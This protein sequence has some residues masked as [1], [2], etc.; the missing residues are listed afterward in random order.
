MSR[1]DDDPYPQSAAGQGDG[2]PSPWARPPA[3]GEPPTA[4][5]PGWAGPPAGPDDSPTMPIS[6]AEPPTAPMPGPYPPSGP[7]PP[8]AAQSPAGPYP[9]GGPTAAYPPGPYQPEGPTAAY[10]PAPYQP[11]EPTAAYP[12]GEPTAAYPPVP[13]PA[14]PYPPGGAVGGGQWAAPP[15]YPAPP[16]R[17]SGRKIALIVGAVLVALLCP[18]LV[19]AGWLIL[20]SG[21]DDRSSSAPSTAVPADPT[22][23]PAEEPT[24]EPTE[25][26]SAPGATDFAKGDCVVN[27]GTSQA[28]ELRKVPC[29]PGTF[30]VLLRI[31]GT[32]E[33]DR[34]A[35]LAPEATANYVSDGPLA[36]QDF[37]LCLRRAR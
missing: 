3:G 31:P 30:E 12:P 17:R 9:S 34:C 24:E 6:G 29:G 37:V 20:P 13:Y 1:P 5:L 32:A 33:G 11:G 22:E 28:A 10:P 16:A 7:F 36:E 21:D 35:R 2:A 23:E 8:P 26:P 18:C 15:G 4:P 19:L 14:G 25:E 27:D